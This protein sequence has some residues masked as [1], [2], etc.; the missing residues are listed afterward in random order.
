MPKCPAGLASVLLL[1]AHS[2][3]FA[4][5]QP[6]IGI[7]LPERTRL[8]VRQRIDLVVEARNL[9]A[10]E[11]FKVTMNGEDITARFSASVRTE[12]DCEA[13][14]LVYR[15]DLFEFQQPGAVKLAVEL[16]A[17]GQTLRAERTLDIK[18][19]VLPQK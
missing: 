4:Q 8:L 12:L 11:R 14:G 2:I 16:L 9:D 13:A 10:A 19:F 7:L 3:A 5:K 6:S 18:P 17:G 15:S 1:V